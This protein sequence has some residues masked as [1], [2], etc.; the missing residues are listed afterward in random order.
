MLRAESGFDLRY[1][2]VD[3]ASSLLCGAVVLKGPLAWKRLES[4]L[5]IEFHALS[6]G[7]RFAGTDGDRGLSG[8]SG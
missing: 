5:L 8:A 3:V 2:F 4:C 7:L 6:A 1:P